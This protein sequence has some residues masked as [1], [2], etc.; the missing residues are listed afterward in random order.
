MGKKYLSAELCITFCRT[1][2]MTPN[3]LFHQASKVRAFYENAHILVTG[4]TGFLG[5]ILIEKLLRGTNPGAV[6]VLIR[7]KKGT[8][9]EK[10]LDELFE[11]RVKIGVTT[12]LV[13]CNN[14]LIT[15]AGFPKT[16]AGKAL[17]QNKIDVYFRRLLVAESGVK[18]V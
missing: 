6:Y 5:K 3:S 4:G 10:R 13:Y 7:N 18:S 17:G 11:N 12:F 8:D 16:Q 14:N 1:S 9:P 2:G 15:I